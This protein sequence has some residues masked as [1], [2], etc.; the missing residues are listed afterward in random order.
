MSSLLYFFLKRAN[1]N[2]KHYS[3]ITMHYTLCTN[4]EPTTKKASWYGNASKTFMAT[5][6]KVLLKRILGAHLNTKDS[7]MIARLSC[8]TIGLGIITLKQDAT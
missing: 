3:I 1:A 8:V 2:G 5:P 7:T 6:D 4:E